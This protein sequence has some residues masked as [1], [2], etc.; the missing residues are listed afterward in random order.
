[1]G[2][3][4]IKKVSGGKIELSDEIVHLVNIIIFF[5][6][7]F[8]AAS[9]VRFNLDLISYSLILS[10]SSLH[11]MKPF[12]ISLFPFMIRYYFLFLKCYD[13]GHINFFNE[14]LCNF[15]VVVGATTDKIGMNMDSK[16]N[17]K[18]SPFY[19]I[20][21]SFPLNYFSIFLI[22]LNSYIVFAI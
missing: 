3:R 22:S 7:F 10:C 4:V 5:L 18:L 1:M 14:E 12:F 21:P 17:M 16:I 19:F 20:C 11:S 15:F 8:M 9:A 13:L 2:S 6:L